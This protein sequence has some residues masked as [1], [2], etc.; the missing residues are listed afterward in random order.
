MFWCCCNVGT[1]NIATDQNIPIQPISRENHQWQRNIFSSGKN[2]TKVIWKF[3]SKD[4]E[5]TLLENFEKTTSQEFLF[6]MKPVSSVF[7]NWPALVTFS[8]V[9]WNSSQKNLCSPTNIS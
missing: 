3:A 2:M 6:L 1:F 5:Q 9:C 7:Q 4:F 8:I